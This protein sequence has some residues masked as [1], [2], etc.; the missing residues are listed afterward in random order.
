MND[1]CSYTDEQLMDKFRGNYQL[2]LTELYNRYPA[3][4]R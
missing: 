2:A 4:L 3:S 1:Y